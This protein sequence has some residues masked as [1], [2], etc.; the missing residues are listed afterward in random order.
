MHLQSVN[1]TSSHLTT[2]PESHSSSST[3]YSSCKDSEPP[4]DQLLLG[5]P[6][7][8]LAF[9]RF[10]PQGTMSNLLVR[11]QLR[12]CYSSLPAT[13]SPRLFLLLLLLLLRHAIPPLRTGRSLTI[14]MRS[15]PEHKK[16]HSVELSHNGDFVRRILPIHLWENQELKRT[17]LTSSC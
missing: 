7:P 17:A 15:L 11:K 12:F 9:L 14:I 16:F 5:R 4:S 8:P 1:S 13:P 10:E 6:L 3:F 2:H